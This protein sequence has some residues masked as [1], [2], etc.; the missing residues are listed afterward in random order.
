LIYW[1]I[2]LAF[3][4][5]GIIAYGGGPASIPLIEY[6]VVHRY[7]WLTRVEFGEALA[8]GNVLPG[9]IATKMA[10]YIGYEVGGIAGGIVAL[11]ATVV[12]SLLLMIALLSI[13][14]RYRDSVRVRRLTII[15]KPAIAVMLTVMAYSFFENSFDQIGPV[16]TFFLG[17]ISLLC[18]E[19]F[20]IHP[21]FILLAALIYG[22]FAF[23]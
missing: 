15:V 9:P 22:G 1:Q 16:H 18:I 11:L 23:S 8:F 3:F 4:I 21:G 14:Y 10:A 20:K 13:L 6:E 12:P 19:K 7:E 17:I 2:F 5:P